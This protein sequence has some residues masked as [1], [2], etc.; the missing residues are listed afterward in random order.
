MRT[1]N[2]MLKFNFYADFVFGLSFNICFKTVKFYLIQVINKSRADNTSSVQTQL[3]L[4][5]TV[6]TR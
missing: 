6:S 3:L 4:V 2:A 1:R 5:V